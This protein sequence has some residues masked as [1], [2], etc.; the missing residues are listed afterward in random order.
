MKKNLIA[1]FMAF[2]LAF[3]LVPAPAL[4]QEATGLATASSD[5]TFATDTGA[6][7][8]SQDGAANAASRDT[9]KVVHTAASKPVI[10]TRAFRLVVPKYWRGKVKRSVTKNDG[11]WNTGKMLRIS[12]KDGSA[13]SVILHFVKRSNY[14]DFSGWGDVSL[15]GKK[16]GRRY[17]VAV[18][19]GFGA[20]QDPFLV[21]RGM[22]LMTGGAA[23]EGTYRNYSTIAAAAK[24]YV[25]KNVL[26]KLK[27]H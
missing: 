8:T 3:G 25:R 15:V 21:S 22:D 11:V 4:A 5:A 19:C 14:R 17:T 18:Y 24:K 10:K 9:S 13:G 6:S 20:G 23:A 7:A 26:K 12:S 2:V 1:T 16:R 27:V